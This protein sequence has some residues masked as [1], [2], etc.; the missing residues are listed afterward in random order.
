M[1]GGLAGPPRVAQPGCPIRLGG[2]QPPRIE[3]VGPDLDR[4]QSLRHRHGR[5]RRAKR[6]GRARERRKDAVVA[7]GLGLH[8]PEVE[9]RGG[10]V[11]VEI[12]AGQRGNRPLLRAGPRLGHHPR[13]DG[14]RTRLTRKFGQDGDRI[15]PAQHQPPPARRQTV[16]QRRQTA[17]QPP[18]VRAAE[19]PCT[20]RRVVQHVDREHG[21][22]RGPRRQRGVVGQAQV[23]AEP[24]D[25]AIHPS[26]CVVIWPRRQCS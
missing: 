6:T 4:G 19:P 14:R 26:Q 7:T 22:S 11:Q 17:V 9:Q 5:R 18:A 2:P 3:R 23:L 24:D 8:R 21:S 10:P 15:A 12:D 16:R 13:M 20:G 25:R 1:S